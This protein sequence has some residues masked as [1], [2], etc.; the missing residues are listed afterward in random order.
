MDLRVLH[1]MKGVSLRRCILIIL[2]L[3]H[4]QNGKVMKM[5]NRLVV[6]KVLAR[7]GK[8]HHKGVALQ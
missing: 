5:H 8:G 7:K 2:L 3:K 4:S 6:A 1:Q